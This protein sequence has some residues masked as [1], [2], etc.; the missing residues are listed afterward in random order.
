MPVISLEDLESL[1]TFLRSV[2]AAVFSVGVLSAGFVLPS[3][4]Q[5]AGI[6]AVV[7]ACEGDC[8]AAVTA[9]MS[10]VPAAQRAAVAQ[11]VAAAL[12]AAAQ[13][14]PAAANNYAAG[15]QAAAN[16]GGGGG[17]NAGPAAS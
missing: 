17:I 13:T 7:A 14:N 5:N 1:M 8:A 12:T 9:Y 2:T 4:A 3:S 10:T 11:Q 16:F 15:V 6:Q